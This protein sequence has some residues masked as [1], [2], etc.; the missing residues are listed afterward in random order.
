MYVW[1]L[2]MVAR[3][4]KVGYLP[5]GAW[6]L[7]ACLPGPL[8]DWPLERDGRWELGLGSAG[9]GRGGVKIRDF[10]GVNLGLAWGTEVGGFRLAGILVVGIVGG[11]L[12]LECYVE[13]RA[14]RARVDRVF[15]LGR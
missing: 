11:E 5:A 8:A 1:Y 13:G 14:F 3:A 9:A 6:T 4:G 7:P 10:R 12:E 15:I 2:V